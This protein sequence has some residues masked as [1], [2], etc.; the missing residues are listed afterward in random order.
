MT[1]TSIEDIKRLTLE[2][3]DVIVLRTDY[4]LDQDEIDAL[5]ATIK[6][7]LPEDTRVIALGGG[8]TLDVIAPA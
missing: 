1:T 7:A 2:P 6:E 4:D 5:I 8:V 3:G